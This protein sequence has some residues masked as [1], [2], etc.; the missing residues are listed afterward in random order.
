LILL[1]LLHC[2]HPL[3]KSFLGAHFKLY[4]WNELFLLTVSHPSS[5]VP[6]VALR[7][8]LHQFSHCCLLSRQVFHCD[9]FFRHI[10]LSCRVFHCTKFF[11]HVFLPHRVFHCVEFFP[12]T[13]LSRRISHCVDFF[14]TDLFVTQRFMLL[15]FLAVSTKFIILIHC[16]KRV[17]QFIVAHLKLTYTSTMETSQRKRKN[18]RS[19]KAVS[20]EPRDLKLINAYPTIRESFE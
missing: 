1:C 6:I 12:H 16:T 4:F 18:A 15:P 13:L 10:F 14:A 2:V 17:L 3:L 8:L 5:E 9:E 19:G 20:F 11:L 7:F